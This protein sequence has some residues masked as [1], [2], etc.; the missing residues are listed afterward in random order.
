MLTSPA[1]AV[2]AL[3]VDI[4]QDCW[5]SWPSW[6]SDSRGYYGDEERQGQ[7]EGYRQRGPSLANRGCEWPWY[8]AAIRLTASNTP[9]SAFPLQRRTPNHQLLGPSGTAPLSP[10]H[11]HTPP[12]L[13]DP[14][15][16]CGCCDAPGDLHRTRYNHCAAF[17]L[18]GGCRGAS[19][20]L[21]ACCR[22]DSAIACYRKRCGSSPATSMLP[23]RRG[24]EP[25]EPR[26]GA[27]NFFLHA[28][29]PEHRGR[30]SSA[31]QSPASHVPA[32]RGSQVGLGVRHQK[33]VRE[34][35]VVVRP[36]RAPDRS[37][38]PS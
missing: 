34:I 38:P 1:A 35:S 32:E 8:V 10:R 16:S 11:T 29:H 20:D 6:S 30:K 5:S 25:A 24:D 33:R 3:A 7:G 21:R 26:R 13:S 22:N 15:A 2:V 36:P 18:P 37:P 31:R 12:T 9:D 28:H 14:V 27:A 19:D 17:D 4:T 23:E